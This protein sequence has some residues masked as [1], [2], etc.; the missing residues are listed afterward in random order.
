M[1]SCIEQS[2]G[3]HLAAKWPTESQD[4]FDV[5]QQETVYLENYGCT[6]P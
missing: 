1:I 3:F 2:D 6:L 4:H 5:T